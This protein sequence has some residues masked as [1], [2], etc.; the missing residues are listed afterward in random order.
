MIKVKVII[1]II[2]IIIIAG[3]LIILIPNEETSKNKIE[4]KWVKSGPFEIDKE[5][6]NV[7]EKIF[8][9]TNDLAIGDEGVVQFLRPINDTHHKSYMKIPFDVKDK[10]QFNYYFEPKINQ[11]QGICSTDDIAGNWVVTF[12]GTQY[13][14]IHFKIL[15]QPSDWDDRS[16]EPVC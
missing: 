11:H 14:N 9:S 5:E 16:Y 6:Y 8:L 4:E 2:I 7:G 3:A 12:S 1:P 13:E 10:S 15:N